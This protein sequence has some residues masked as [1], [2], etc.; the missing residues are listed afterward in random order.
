MEDSS[1][2]LR[3]NTVSI[4][5]LKADSRSIFAICFFTAN[6]HKNATFRFPT[7]RFCYAKGKK[8]GH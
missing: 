1:F 6:K 4:D 8:Y 2:S 7:K 5:T 3:Q